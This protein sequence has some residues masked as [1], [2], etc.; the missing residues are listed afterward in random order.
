MIEHLRRKCKIPR[1]SFPSNVDKFG[2]TS[3]ASIPL[4]LTSE[5][6]DIDNGK[7]IRLALIGFGV[8]LSWAA[9]SITLDDS[10]MLLT[11]YF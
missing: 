8:G 7:D 10:S 4:L 11:T 2:N 3:S 1:E 9:A 6:G 5:L